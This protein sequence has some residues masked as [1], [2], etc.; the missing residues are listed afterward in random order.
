MTRR[1]LT[2]A[3]LLS[4]LLFVATLVVWMISEGHAVNPSAPDE[5]FGTAKGILS[6]FDLSSL[7]A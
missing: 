1:L 5:T 3:S 2:L 4:L 6:H 7:F